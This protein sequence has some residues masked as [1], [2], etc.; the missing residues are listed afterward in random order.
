M[1]KVLEKTLKGNFLL[2]PMSNVVYGENSV[3]Q[4]P[5]LL[6]M[7]GIKNPYI[8]T[9][10][11][12]ANKTPLV[13][14]LESIIGEDKVAGVFTECKAHVPKRMV[15]EIANEMRKTNADGIISFGGGSPV[16]AAKSVAMVLAEE[17]YT[18]EQLN[19]Y[20]IKFDYRTDALSFRPLTANPL[21]HIAITTTLSAGE[22]THIAG[23][24]DEV[25][26]VKVGAIDPKLTP[27]AVI[28]DP[29]LTLHTPD[30]LWLSTGLRAVDHAVES[31]CSNDHMPFTDALGKEALQLLITYL[32][33]CKENPNDLVARSYCQ[34]A[35]WLSISGL[36]NVNLG[37]SHGIG[38]QLG[39]RCGVPH[40]VTSCVMLPAVMEYNLE[41]T[42]ERQA[43]IARVIGAAD[44][45]ESDETAA[46]KAAPA[47]REF[48]QN[49]G[50]PWRLRDT[51]VKQSDF[52][53]LAKDALEDF[54]VATN[55]RKINGRDDVI[56]LLEKAW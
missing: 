43:M 45:T 34:M 23:M 48:I 36:A 52:E 28:H 54:I 56:G 47:I 7:N 9:G 40:G 20:P 46:S 50:L 33:K 17:I 44:H 8:I 22:F 49:L 41:V 1:E 21:P 11:S 32:P 38:H 14:R 27:V 5:Q 4:L 3:E 13:N 16:D 37:L 10:N 12:L 30:W 26:K 18:I 24:T 2:L 25:T 42:K 6:E 19:E 29:V 39:G 51:E 35:A 15:L 31:I 55:P 53:A